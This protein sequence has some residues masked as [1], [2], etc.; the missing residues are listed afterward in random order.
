MLKPYIDMNTK[1][2]KKANNEFEKDFSKLM[3]NSV[4]GKTLENVRNH[5]DIKLVSTNEK[6]R[7]YVSEQNYMTS[8]CFSKDLMAIE[9]RKTK[10]LMNNPVYLGQAILNISKT[11]IYEFYYNYLKLKYGD[12]VKLCYMGTDSFIIHVQTE[13]L[14]KDIADDVNKWFDTSG[15]DEKLNRPLTTGINKKVIGKFKDELNGL[16]TTEFCAPRAKTYVFKYNEN[17][18]RK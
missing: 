8:K 3:N 13:D 10:I 4:F 15:Y 14:Y 17:D 18:K 5:R 2:R 7:K 16:I 11:L 6:R 1:L 9:M 12:R